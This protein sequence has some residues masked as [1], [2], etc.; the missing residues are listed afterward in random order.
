MRVCELKK[1]DI[2]HA[3]CEVM[4]SKSKSVTQEIEFGGEV[5]SM[6]IRHKGVVSLI[7][8]FDV[9]NG[10]LVDSKEVKTLRN[11]KVSW[12]LATLMNHEMHESIITCQYV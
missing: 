5:E 12:I 4:K 11:F 3:A 8:R 10:Q 2:T 1:Y 6:S 7:L 9:I